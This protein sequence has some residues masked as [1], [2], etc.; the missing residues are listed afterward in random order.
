MQEIKLDFEN[1]AFENAINFFSSVK[2]ELFNKIS[3]NKAK[4]LPLTSKKSNRS[5]FAIAASIAVLLLIGSIYMYS[6]LNSVKDELQIVSEE[7]LILNNQIEDLNASLE[8]NN[9]RYETINDPET[10]K[11]VLRGNHLM[12]VATAISYVNDSK[13]NRC[14]KHKTVT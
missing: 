6:E 4:T 7:N 1:L 3:R 12:P 2:E 11:Y 10:E 14:N 5:Y 13:K 8:E 9:K